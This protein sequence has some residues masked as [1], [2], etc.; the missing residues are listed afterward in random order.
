MARQST[1]RTTPGRRGTARRELVEAE[2]HEHAAKLFAERGFAGTSLQDIADSV[3]ITR[4]A[5]YYYVK[6]KDEMLGRLVADLTS[7]LVAQMRKVSEEPGLDPADRLYRI[8]HL[9]ATDRAVN[10]TRFQLLDRSASALP[11]SLAD[12]YLEGRRAALAEVRSVID[13]GIAQGLFRPVD[14]R[15]AALSVLGMC[16]WVA[17]WFEAGPDHPVEPIA[18]QIASSAVA[19]LRVPD[20][21]AGADPRAALAA[22][23]ASLD[24]L[25]R[26][27]QA[28]GTPRA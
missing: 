6:S 12:A 13:D 14:S 27:L 11:D 19:M 5:L 18:A 17:W 1:A 24:Q 10:R 23:R 21:A 16:N 15:V 20:E 3:G 4:Q 9:T 2:I 8:A 22:A 25:E 7:R 28:N 26:H